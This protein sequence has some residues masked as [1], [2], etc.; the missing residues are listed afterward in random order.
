MRG[1]EDGRTDGDERGDGDF[2]IR[3]WWWKVRE[4]IFHFPFS[5]FPFPPP[6]SNQPP[7]NQNRTVK[8]LQSSK[9]AY[10]TM[11]DNTHPHARIG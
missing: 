3:W 4:E 8:S 5:P 2:S 10:K 1:K 7:Q 11:I 9:L 6:S